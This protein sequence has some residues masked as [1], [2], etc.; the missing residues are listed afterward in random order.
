M[1]SD[2]PDLDLQAKRNGMDASD[3]GA[4]AGDAFDLGDEA[5]A[6]QR[7]KRFRGDVSSKPQSREHQ[8][9]R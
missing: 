2:I 4:A 7:L 9:R 3:L 6:D 8:L 5:A 1:N